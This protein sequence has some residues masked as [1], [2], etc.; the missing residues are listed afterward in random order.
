MLQLS[1]TRLR[2][3]GLPLII[4]DIYCAQVFELLVKKNFVKGI[5]VNLYKDELM[6]C[7]SIML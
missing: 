1:G 2:N 5:I 3:C 6:C 7:F 4:L